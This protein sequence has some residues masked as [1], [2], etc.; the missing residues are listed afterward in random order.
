MNY[1][2]FFGAASAA[3]MIVIAIFILAPGA[4]A[5]SEY[6]TLHAFMDGTDGARSFGGLVLDEAGHLYGTTQNGGTNELGTVFELTPN[7]DGTWTETVLY[8]FTAGSDGAGPGAGLILDQAG[9]LY[10]TTRGGGG[11]G[12]TVFKLTPNIDG[13]WT[14]T[15]LYSFG[16]DGFDPDKGLTFDG[17]GNLYGTTSEG[18]EYNGG[19]VFELTPNADGSW[20]E[21]LLHSFKRVSLSEAA[22]PS[23]LTIDHEG[24]LYGATLFGGNRRYCRGN[25]CGVVFK[26]TANADGSWT[27]SVL[28][29][30]TGR[31]NGALPW[32]RLTFDQAGNLYGTTIDGGRNP[33]GCHSQYGCGVV[34]KLTLSADGSWTESVPY[35]FTGGKNGGAPFAGVTFDQAGN[36]YGTA[37]EGGN[38]NYCDGLG[39]GVVFKL[40][41]G[42][43]GKWRNRVLHG[44]TARPGALPFAEVIFDAAG[45]LYSTTSGYFLTSYGSVFEITP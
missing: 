41:L 44:F 4:C 14:E 15:V 39:C 21:A 17:A 31:N 20:K 12:G 25:G 26:L 36:L 35:R 19:T 27:E 32:A 22:V 16:T 6:K 24:N 8:R 5:Q 33:L 28:Y 23:E 45:N 40:T 11:G 9:N 3:L 42:S 34:F 13:T 37:N 1:K 43:D 2:R 18:G 38:L 7:T 30:F 10:G 29:R